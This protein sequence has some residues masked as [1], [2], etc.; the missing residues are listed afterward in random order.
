MIILFGLFWHL[1]LPLYLCRGVEMGSWGKQ[2]GSMDEEL[3]VRGCCNIY[4][5]TNQPGNKC[6]LSP[7]ENMNTGRNS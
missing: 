3:Q 5:Y 1:L 2:V 4:L 7:D 6:K